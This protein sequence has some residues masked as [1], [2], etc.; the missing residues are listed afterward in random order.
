MTFAY[1]IWLILGLL[2]LPALAALYYQAEKNKT[3]K[4]AHFAAAKL[5]LDLAASFSPVKRNIKATLSVIG[6]FLI[7]I[8]LAQPQW[9]Y[10]W[11]ETKGKGIDILI[12]LDTSKSMLAEDIRPNRLE[13]AKLAI[14]DLAERVEG[15]R[16]GLI[17]F[18][19]SAF[20]QCPL[21]L[22]YDAFSQ[23]LETVDTGIISR[24]GTN[25][26]A[27]IAEAE[28]SFAEK[29]NFKILVLITDGEDLRAAGIEQARK[30][31]E[32]GVKIY[33]VGV[34]SVSGELIPVRDENGGVDFL[35]DEQGNVVK[36]RLDENTLAT[37]SEVTDGF[38]TH[39]GS[40]GQGLEQVYTVGL[41]SIPKEER[42]AR[43]Q[44][45][46]QERFQ[47][48]LGLAVLFLVAETFLGT[49][50][51]NIGYSPIPL[52][53]TVALALAALP[54]LE[55]SLKASPGKGEK[56]F[57]EGDFEK[58]GEEYLKAA[59][60]K[61]DD[62]R[63]QY[64]LGATQYRLGHFEEAEQTLSKA[65][66][67]DDPILQKDAYYNL[68]NTHYRLGEATKEIDPAGTI[69]IWEEGLKDYEN[70]LNIAPEDEDAKFNYDLL[71]KRIEALKEQQQEQNQD[72]KDQED[73]EEGEDQENQDSD[74][75]QNQDQQDSKEE[76]GQE[77]DQKESE[78]GEDEQSQN[79]D[80]KE[81]EQNEEEGQQQ[82][83]EGDEK[84]EGEEEQAQS[85]PGRMSREEARHLLEA[86]RNDE[87][88]LP[89]IQFEVA[90][91]KGEKNAPV[92]DW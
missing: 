90:D 78:K 91:P 84:K 23:T 92:R 50:K 88:K 32:N 3:K 81:G 89:V 54:V 35:R 80:Q 82:S 62:P 30:A 70:S 36:T 21:T 72:N 29:D 18:S 67:T 1:N 9:G 71:K 59:E 8:A 4:L 46:P 42:E 87:K 47:W 79:Q 33:T 28:V 53:W 68:G 60:D 7:M 73:K 24:G 61:P 55:T 20:L 69:E 19:G 64:N 45:V 39:L 26:A 86:M 83:S 5:L 38:Y 49:R 22:D 66:E 15:D 56:F 10:D 58:A 27:A 2:A 25:I 74:S 65:L 43:L 85:I 14:L 6:I 13:R 52:R 77:Q 12:A 31:A 48:P 40:T 57:Q 63:L 17:A 44:Q 51:R 76:E 11:Q 37:I 34:G 41:Q 16:L 75:E